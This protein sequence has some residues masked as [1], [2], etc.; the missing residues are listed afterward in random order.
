MALGRFLAFLLA[1]YIGLAL[2]VVA[3]LL[4]VFALGVCVWGLGEWAMAPY[5]EIIFEGLRR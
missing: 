5:W 4:A 2:I 1:A 3:S